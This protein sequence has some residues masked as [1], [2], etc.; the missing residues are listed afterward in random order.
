M[1]DWLPLG[2]MVEGPAAPREEDGPSTAEVEGAGALVQ[3]AGENEL[4]ANFSDSGLDLD[5]LSFLRS[6]SSQGASG[7]SSE[8]PNSVCVSCATLIG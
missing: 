8:A 4:I 7:V 2:G 1:Y 5:G 6:E 3:S